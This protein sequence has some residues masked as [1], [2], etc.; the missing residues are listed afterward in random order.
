MSIG[1]PAAAARP[2]AVGCRSRSPTRS[3]KAHP[4]TPGRTAPGRRG[5]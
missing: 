4:S 1:G 3:P 2:A 5:P